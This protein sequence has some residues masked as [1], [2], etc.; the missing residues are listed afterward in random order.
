MGNKCVSC[1]CGDLYISIE[2]NNE[3]MYIIYTIESGHWGRPDTAY[4]L[5]MNREIL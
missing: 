3:I 2:F 4:F 1:C 5:I